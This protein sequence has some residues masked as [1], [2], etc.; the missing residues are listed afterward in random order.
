[1]NKR[2]DGLTL[3]EGM[4]MDNLAEAWNMFLKL[5][6][7]HPSEQDNFAEGIHKCQQVLMNRILR[8]DYPEGYPT[9]KNKKVSELNGK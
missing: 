2:K 5:E 4:I 3:Q 1:M 8:R 6:Q 9:Y 7:T